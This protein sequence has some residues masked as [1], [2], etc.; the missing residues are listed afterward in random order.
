MK[1]NMKQLGYVE[2][3]KWKK[4]H[5]LFP[6]WYSFSSSAEL[7]LD[8]TE[9]ILPKGIY[10]LK[11]DYPLSIPFKVKINSKGMTREQ[12]I[13]EVVKRYKQVYREEDKSS[14][15]KPLLRKDGGNAPLLN[16]Q[17]TDGK[18]GIWGHVLSDLILH[19]LYI[20]GKTL[21]VGVDS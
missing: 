21:T 4:N 16:R 9:V 15:I 19:T 17:Q 5:P 3:H 10:T 14:K 6:K 11:I 1:D 20:R 2:M 8:R 12:V 18:Y 7:H 13:Q